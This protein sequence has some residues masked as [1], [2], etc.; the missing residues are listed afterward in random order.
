MYNTS[1]SGNWRVGVI[2][3]IL[4]FGQIRI[5]LE[6][7][8]E[9]AMELRQLRYFLMVAEILHF[10]R[11]AERLHIAQQPLSFQVKQLENE[12]GV[13]LFERTTR[14][15]ALTPAGT[16]LLAEV[17]AGL[18]RIERGVEL[19][20]RI[21]R[22]EDGTIYIGYTGTTVY[23]VMPPI[24]RRFREQFPQIEV[25]LLELEPPNLERQILSEDID[26]GIVPSIG[27]KRR[28]LAYDTIYQE[29][30]VVALP[31]DH[32]LAQRSSI[33]LRELADEP[34]VMY[35]RSANRE[36]FDEIIA[37]CHLAGFSP[38]IVQEAA[39][40]S[41]MVGLVAAGL[42]VS[43][44]GR[45]LSGLWTDEVVY[46][47]LVNP[48]VTIEVAVVWKKDKQLPWLHE[49]RQIAQGVM[50]QELLDEQRSSTTKDAEG[51]P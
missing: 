32:P 5:D 17:Q 19:A 43:L 4:H 25:A 48:P 50:Q 3:L 6:L 33:S 47:Q 44:V 1:I 46:R 42:G 8:L 39:T 30:V 35:A 12:L 13:K 7:T 22:G 37:L 51:G 18:E 27:S 49:F 2:G 38:T 34:F 20:Q 45:S 9:G 23:N 14:S 31:K 28:G 29:F 10:G 36:L 16:A 40:M 15:V 41:A 24:V 26:I 11:A 21:A